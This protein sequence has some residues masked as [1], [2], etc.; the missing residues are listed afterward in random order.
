MGESEAGEPLVR[1]TRE[2]GVLGIEMNRVRQRNAVDRA[3][4][5][6]LSAA[7]DELD[8]DPSLRV[9]ILAGNGPVFCAG[10]DLREGHSPATERGGEYG[11]V[12]RKRLKPVIAA[13]EGPALGGGFELVLSCDLVVAGREASF[14]LPEVKRGLVAACGGLFRTPHALPPVLA[15][16]L[17]LT[18]EP[19][20]AERALAGGLVNLVCE[21]GEAVA[22]AGEL[23]ARITQNSPDAVSASLRALHDSRAAAEA[24]GWTAT[25]LAIARITLSPDRVEG[26]AAFLEKRA[27]SWTEQ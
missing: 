12:R 5:D 21:P 24:T 16:E 7:F 11:L 17:L 1:T 15:A 19:I 4:A 6:G 23:A 25:D 20:S 13:V 14:G 9:G 2:G 22:R 26:V 27:P 10:T 18:G 8:D 3:L